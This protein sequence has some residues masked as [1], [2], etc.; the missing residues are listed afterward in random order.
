MAC[1]ALPLPCFDL[2]VLLVATTKI[3]FGRHKTKQSSQKGSQAKKA[4]WP[5][6]CFVLSPPLG[7]AQVN[8][9]TNIEQ[10]I[11]LGHLWYL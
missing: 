9:F 5:A 3:H 11:F 10:S 1:T 7:L 4:A 6:A 2:L 8:F